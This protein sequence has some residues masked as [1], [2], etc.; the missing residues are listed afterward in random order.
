VPVAPRCGGH[1]YA[2]WSSTTGL[3]LDVT[4]M[5]SV[6]VDSGSGTAT[7]AAGTRLIDLYG[8][9]HRY[10]SGQAY[11]NYIDPSL[12]NWKQAYYGANYTR[13][14]QVKA[15]YDPG[16]LFRFPQAIG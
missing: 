11:Q 4:A 7:V 15:R 13:L 3:V 2:G 1:S 5:S 12:A 9:A 14:A 8:T 6:Q 10:A 16:R